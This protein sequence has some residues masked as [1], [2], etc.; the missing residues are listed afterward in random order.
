MLALV[1]I[2]LLDSSIYLVFSKQERYKDLE[3]EVAT[4]L[5]ISCLLP[6][7]SA[8]QKNIAVGGYPENMS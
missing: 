5:R 7:P 1:Y 8:N 3:K 4:L 2:R 6:Q